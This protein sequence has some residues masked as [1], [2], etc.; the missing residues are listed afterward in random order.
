MRTD[1]FGLAPRQHDMFGVPQETFDVPMTVAE[2]RA[3]LLTTLDMLR[4]AETMPWPTRM[5][6]RIETMFPDIA[7]K[8]PADEAEAL[9]G[10]FLCEMSRLRAK[11]A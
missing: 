6:L 5:M 7:A 11:A 4:A 3:E 1:I 8:L 9:V 2:I 10:R